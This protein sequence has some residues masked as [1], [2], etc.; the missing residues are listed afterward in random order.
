MSILKTGL[1]L[2]ASRTGSEESVLARKRVAA[3]SEGARGIG[4][5]LT[6]LRKAAGITQVE[7]AQRLNSTQGFVSKYERG[8]L[9]LHGE[10][11]AQLAVVLHVTTD[12][13]LGVS[14][15]K[16]KAAPAPRPVDRN[17]ARRLAQLQ[18]LPRRDRDALLRTLDAF[19]ALRLDS[20]TRNHGRAA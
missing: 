18:S 3:T 4:E 8:D 12:E 9:L 2:P 20:R 15:S 6:A 7:M 10:L 13:I 11:I 5:R 14:R 1:T 19:L 17:L 16:A